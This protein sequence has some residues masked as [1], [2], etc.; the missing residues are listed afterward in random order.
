[1]DRVFVPSVRPV[2]ILQALGSCCSWASSR[3]SIPRFDQPRCA[4]RRHLE[5]VEQEAE[6]VQAVGDCQP[7]ARPGSGKTT[8]LNLI[9]GLTRPTRDEICVQARSWTRCRTGIWPSSG[10]SRSASSSRPATCCR[11][12]PRSRTR[13]PDAAPG[14]SGG[15]AVEA[16]PRVLRA[17]RQTFPCR[18]S[19]SASDHDLRQRPASRACTA[20][21]RVLFAIAILVPRIIGIAP[22]RWGRPP[23]RRDSSPA[24]VSAVG[25][26]STPKP[27]SSSAQVASSRGC[28]AP[29]GARLGCAER[30]A[31]RRSR[32]P[33]G[34]AA[35]SEQM[36][37]S[38]SRTCC[39]R[40]E[41]LSVELDFVVR[42]P[43]LVLSFAA[44]G[45]ASSCSRRRSVCQRP[46][47]WPG[48]AAEGP[49][50]G[51]A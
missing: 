30:G 44:W 38:S 41:P 2:R 37:Q 24:P 22:D 27:A 6:E 9:G 19:S 48:P 39:R 36:I 51:T 20:S 11:C 12:S 43:Q 8:L 26:T 40:L 21:F 5:V 35:S 23:R 17:D 33:L 1:M 7:D 34:W 4:H 14:R 47:D 46:P 18:P 28:R 49:C 45:G 3:P 10:S 31:S 15:R 50:H 13:V 42:Q 29:G 25:C 16:A 32:G